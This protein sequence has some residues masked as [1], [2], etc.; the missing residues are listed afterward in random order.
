LPDHPVACTKSQQFSALC[1]SFLNQ[2]L[3]GASHVAISGITS[4]VL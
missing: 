2:S 1:P 4:Q 3:S